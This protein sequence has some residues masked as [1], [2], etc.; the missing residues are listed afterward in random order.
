[1]SDAPQE[2]GSLEAIHVS[3]EI[4]TTT[5]DAQTLGELDQL[6][7]TKARGEL[8]PKALHIEAIDKLV[9]HHAGE[10]IRLRDDN[11]KLQNR[12]NRLRPQYAALDQAH[13][14]ASPKAILAS[15]GMTLGGGAVSA[16]GL[17]DNQICRYSTMW[18]GVGVLV[19]GAL[20]LLV[21]NLSGWP[22]SLTDDEL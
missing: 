13:K 22:R 6:S 9:A 4:P 2:K 19:F 1:M 11:C 14:S 8:T 7:R 17:F 20:L 16:A 21:A 3:G 5:P 10:C 15:I 12:L 18:A